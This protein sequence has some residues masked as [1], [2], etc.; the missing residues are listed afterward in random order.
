VLQRHKEQQDVA[1]A[2]AAHPPIFNISLGNDFANILQPPPIANQLPPPAYPQPQQPHS[3]LLPASHLP[4]LD[5]SLANFCQIYQLGDPILQKFVKNNFVQ[6]QM[7]RFVQ[8][9]ELKE[10]EFLL[11]EIAALKDTV[12]MWSVAA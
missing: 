1:A 6:L 9:T 4:G 5:M 8:I 11:G 2:A 12:K 7:L 3:F 10:M